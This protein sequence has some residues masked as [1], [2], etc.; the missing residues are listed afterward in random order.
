VFVEIESLWVSE[1]LRQ[2]IV[3]RFWLSGEQFVP[4]FSLRVCAV[5]NLE[6]ALPVIFV[7]A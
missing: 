1:N 6:P 7:N 5:L 2:Q 4:A 3:S